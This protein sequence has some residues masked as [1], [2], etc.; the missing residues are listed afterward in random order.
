MV[1]F[2]NILI[3]QN[4]VIIINQV[5]KL[6][7]LKINIVFFPCFGKSL[8]QFLLGYVKKHPVLGSAVC[9]QS[10]YQVVWRHYNEVVQSTHTC[11]LIVF[12]CFLTRTLMSIL[13]HVFSQYNSF[14]ELV[15]YI[16]YPLIGV[17]QNFIVQFSICSKNR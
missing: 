8:L 16:I 9:E 4:M 10:L 5:W 15:V 12:N 17:V 11:Q 7:G 2:L 14:H 3:E 6:Q 13:I 1:D